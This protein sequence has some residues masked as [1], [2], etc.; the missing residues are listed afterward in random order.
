MTLNGVSRLPRK[1]TLKPLYPGFVSR[2]SKQFENSESTPNLQL[3]A[4]YM[5]GD[6]KLDCCLSHTDEWNI[7]IKRLTVAVRCT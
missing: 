3:S 5:L 4:E 7:V 1:N 6:F 2:W